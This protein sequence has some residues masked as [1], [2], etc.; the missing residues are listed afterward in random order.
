MLCALI[1]YVRFWYE[2][3]SNNKHRFALKNVRLTHHR[4]KQFCLK[5]KETNYFELK[6]D[7]VVIVDNSSSGAILNLQVFALKIFQLKSFI[8][9][10]FFR[11]IAS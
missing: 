11:E 2:P 9:G 1:F 10:V 5:M 4:G 7:K 6:I 8:L 3:T